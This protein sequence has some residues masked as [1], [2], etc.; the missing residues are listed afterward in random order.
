MYSENEVEEENV[1]KGGSNG[2]FNNKLVLIVI[3]LVVFVVAAWLVTRNK[4]GGEVVVNDTKPSISYKKENDKEISTLFIQKGTSDYLELTINNPTKDGEVVWKVNDKSLIEIGSD[5]NG[6][7]LIT[8][9]DKIGETTVEASYKYG[10]DVTDPLTFVVSVFIGDENVE[11]QTVAFPEQDLMINQLTSNYDISDKLIIIPNGGY[12]VKREFTSSNQSV[13]AVTDDGKISALSEGK[14]TITAKINNIYEASMDVYI[15]NDTVTPGLV[16]NPVSISFSGN[17]LKL[18]K[19]EIVKLEPELLP[20]GASDKYL[21]WKSSNESVAKV[22]PDGSVTALEIGD[23]TISVESINGQKG[24]VLI[25]VENNIIPIETITFQT[26]SITL[27]EGTTQTIFPIITPSDASNK[28]LV[29][30]PAN[31]SIASVLTGEGGLSATVYGHTRGN[32]TITATSIDGNVSATLNV[33]VTKPSGSSS[34]TDSSATYTTI[35]VRVADENGKEQAVPDKKCSSTLEIKDYPKVKITKRNGISYITWCV[36][37]LGNAKCNPSN[38]S[39]KET[40]LI[41]L[42]SNQ[43][44]LL[45]IRKYDLNGNEVDSSNSDNYVDGALEYYINRTS[46]TSVNCTSSSSP[47]PTGNTPCS[48][49]YFR[50][51]YG[52]E[53]CPVGYK[54]DGLKRTACNTL[55]SLAYQD[56]DGQS[57]CKTCVSPK[58]ANSSGT[59][60][61][62]AGSQTGRYAVSFISSQGISGLSKTSD[63]CDPGNG[64]SCTV[65]LPS[66]TGKAGGFELIGYFESSNI[67]AKDNISGNKITLKKSQTTIEVRYG[68]TVNG[69]G[70]LT[71]YCD[72]DPSKYPDFIS[73]TRSGYSISGT[74]YKGYYW[75]DETI[76][77][78]NGGTKNSTCSTQ[79]NY[80]PSTIKRYSVSF[81]SSQ[82]I[83]GL[84]KTS[85][86]CDPG[87]GSSCT[88]ELPSVTGKAGGFEL[89]GYFDGTGK[90]LSI[91]NNSIELTRNQM[92]VEVRYG[93]TVSG[94]GG[95]TSYCDVDPSKYP[96]FISITRS[97]NSI[98][99]TLYKG[100]YWKDGTA[101]GT[102]GGSKSGTC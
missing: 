83:S 93:L 44:S 22:S 52:C 17:L 102:N 51:Q 57:A 32:T 27:E 9:K 84:S 33:T 3:G 70:G 92:K 60:C 5:N 19:E 43:V 38:K 75:K 64:S 69:A 62:D 86:S 82:G 16:T 78:T 41:D 2:L 47:N 59:A 87:N 85:D 90:K 67:N 61:I 98:S 88:V 77:G 4:N 89:I 14:A 71:S 58:V 80:S 6:R 1:Q 37:K 50:G 15:S 63:S 35:V 65:E 96:D 99:G 48:S 25:T 73:I 10:N 12:I 95:L 34:N 94:A 39:T 11:V 7:V 56:K 79:A 74:L 68:L 8:S 21:S 49:G 30:T 54:C 91:N 36:S 101:N 29:Y 72:V 24:E 45:R 81:V 53:K 42:A 100:Y 23:A 55:G 28:N 40:T 66:V 97:G 20:N 26:P 18:K 13:L 46:S 76:S 31:P